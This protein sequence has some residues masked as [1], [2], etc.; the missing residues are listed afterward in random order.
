MKSPN[1]ECCGKMGQGTHTNPRK[2]VS[3]L[4]LGWALDSKHGSTTL[5]EHSKLLNSH[6]K[7]TLF[8]FLVGHQITSH[9]RI[10]RTTTLVTPCAGA[11]DFSSLLE[12]G[13]VDRYHSMSL[14]V[15]YSPIRW[16]SVQVNASLW[17]WYHLELVKESPEDGFVFCH[18]EGTGGKPKNWIWIVWVSWCLHTLI[19]STLCLLPASS[20]RESC[21]QSSPPGN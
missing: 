4:I 11:T 19:S 5:L 1:E 13:E 17:A 6:S 21:I 8:A 14:N 18:L 16:I 2:L 12:R 9:F 15:F 10:Q 7:L 20:S 3:W